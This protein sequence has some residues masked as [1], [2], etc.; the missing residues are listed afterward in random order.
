M[1]KTL[2][3]TLTLA[4][5]ALFGAQQTPPANGS[6]SG[7]TGATAKHGRRHHKKANKAVKPGAQASATDKAAGQTK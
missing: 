7:T 3:A 2:I 4:T 5:A 1:K 6:A